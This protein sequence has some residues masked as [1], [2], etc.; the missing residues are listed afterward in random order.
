MDVKEFEALKKEFES[1][2]TK[3]IQL[4]TQKSEIEK[5]WKAEYGTKDPAEIEKI[6]EEKKKEIE[7]LEGKREKLLTSLR[8]L[9]A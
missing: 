9:L 1:K 2:K 6:L 3:K 8:E 4:E 7:L 5:G